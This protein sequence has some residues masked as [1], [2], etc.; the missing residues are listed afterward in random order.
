[1]GNPK[2]K[3][4]NPKSGS[5]DRFLDACLCKPVDR[6]PVWFLRQ[7]GRYLPEF[8]ALRKKHDFIEMCRRPALSIEAALQPLRRFPLDASIVFSDIL[9]PFFDSPWRLEYP[10]TGGP[11]FRRPPTVAD[12]AEW[13]VPDA[14]ENHPFVARA[15]AGLKKRIGDRALI[16]FAGGPYTLLHYIMGGPPPRSTSLALLRKA[17]RSLAALSEGS[18][19]M[20]VEA[21]ADAVQLFDTR[22]GEQPDRLFRDSALPHARRVVRTLRRLGVPVI[23][24]TRGTAAHVAELPLVGADVLSIDDSVGLGAARK[25]W[26]TRVAVQGN[27]SPSVLRGRSAD[28]ARRAKEIIAEN[29]GRPGFIF[30]TSEGLTPETRPA[31]VAAVVRAVTGGG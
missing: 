25:G 15:V 31:C 12:I 9:A 2:S 17:L 19:K 16:G 27:L 3:T 24:Y 30:N 20:Q 10:G 13:D 21:G 22:A 1:M 7:A 8:R 26:G 29:G 14:H 11:A 4:P 18:L 28:A 6:P 5:R 23:Y